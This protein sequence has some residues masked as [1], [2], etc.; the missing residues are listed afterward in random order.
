[1]KG[2]DT[3]TTVSSRGTKGRLIRV[4]D[5]LWKAYLEA[6]KAE[7]TTGSE[8]I[9]Q[10]MRDKVTAHEQPEDAPATAED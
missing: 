6:C 7:G 5:D 1:M 10:H 4:E 8:D 3:L 9:R 2:V